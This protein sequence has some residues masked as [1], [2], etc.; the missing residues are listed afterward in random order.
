MGNT[1][2]AI[3]PH[4]TYVTQCLTAVVPNARIYYTQISPS[5]SFEDS[6][7]VLVNS[8]CKII[9]M[10]F[11]YDN[12]L[13]YNELYD[14]VVDRVSRNSNVLFIKSAGNTGKEICSPG[15]AY[16]AVTVAN[17]N[18][19]SSIP[20]ICNT[21]SYIAAYK[22]DIAAPG[23][24]NLKEVDGSVTPG[25]GTSL[26]AP[27]VAGVAEMIMEAGDTASKTTPTYVKSVLLCAANFDVIPASVAV[28]NQL[29]RR[30]TYTAN[31]LLLLRIICVTA[32]ELVW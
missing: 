27:I 6:I 16:C 7:E 30:G 9:N 31:S 32:A 13:Q 4:A 21:S 14:E 28:N 22:P 23:H 11:G 20:G 25:F 24:F 10:S 19:K 3:K 17:Y 1:P 18:Q 2:I 15:Y 29:W 26:S 8:G 5:Q 12:S